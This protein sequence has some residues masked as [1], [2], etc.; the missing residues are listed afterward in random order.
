MLIKT[1]VKIPTEISNKAFL[2]KLNVFTKN[3]FTF[4]NKDRGAMYKEM[5]AEIQW[6]IFTNGLTSN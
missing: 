5:D 2:W 1:Y 6:N 3:G 4:V